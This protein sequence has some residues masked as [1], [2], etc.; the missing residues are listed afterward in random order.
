MFQD[1]EDY[2]YDLYYAQTS[3]DIWFDSN[4]IMVRGP[5]YSEVEVGFQDEDDS[6]DSNAESNWKN[7]YPDTDPDRSAEDDDDDDD[8]LD[9]SDD[10]LDLSLDENGYRRTRNEYGY[11]HRRRQELD[12]S[13]DSDLWEGSLSDKE[14]IVGEISDHDEISDDEGTENT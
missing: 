7:E 2:V 14:E 10:Y 1:I 11:V 13:S 4:N 8:D 5:G 3:D 9:E 6:S 12:N